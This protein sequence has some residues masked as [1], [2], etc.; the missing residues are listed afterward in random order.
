MSTSWLRWA[1]AAAMIGVA[2]FHV[3]RMIAPRARQR[4]DSMDAEITHAAMGV[5]MTVML[6]GVL[7]P[8]EGRRLAVL[9]AIPLVWFVWRGLHS[10]VMD[11]PQAVGTPTRHVVG[12]AAMVYMLVAVSGPRAASSMPGM[13]MA[14]TSPSS[15]VAAGALLVATVGVA[16]WT[17]ARPRAVGLPAQPALAAGCQLAMNAATVY[18]LLAL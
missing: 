13:S 4:P 5:V 7:A 3:I 12:C 18:M 1:F 16:L 11:G 8:A 14:S 15:P 6:L 2:L 9:F 10:Y 17:V